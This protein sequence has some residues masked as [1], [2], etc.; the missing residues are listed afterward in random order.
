MAK[1]AVDITLLPSEEMTSKV[2]EINKELLKSNKPR[3]VLNKR[4]CL[5]HISLAMGCIKE[6][7]L[8][9]IKVIIQ[10]ISNEFYKMKLKA[11]LNSHV[12]KAGDLISSLN[13]EKTPELQ[14]L[15]EAVMMR[16]KPF[17][18]F[19]ATREMFLGKTVQEW[20]LEKT[21]LRWVNE[22]PKN[23]ASPELF[24]PHI[25]IGFGKTDKFDGVFEFEASTLI[26]CHLGAYCT[27][28]KI[29]FQ[30]KLK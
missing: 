21:T 27:C 4:G 12:Y 24:K 11:N 22:Y 5:P 15:H 9:K 6:R 25:T 8:Q 20:D 2:V 10:E 28:R 30:T 19:D 14:K 7:D 13:V 29:L 18:T 17:F 3:I 26:L 23:N 1:I 16:L